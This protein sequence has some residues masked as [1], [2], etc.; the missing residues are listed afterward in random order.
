MEH[1]FFENLLAFAMF[2]GCAVGAACAIAHGRKGGK[3]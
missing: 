2:W 1:T 3:K